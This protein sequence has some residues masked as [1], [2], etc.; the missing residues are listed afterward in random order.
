MWWRSVFDPSWTISLQP[1]N[2]TPWETAVN[3]VD[4]QLVA[5]DPVALVAASRSPADCP[6][7]W[8]PY[9]AAE[10]SVDEF[11]SSWPE[12]RRR[13]VIADALPYHKVK[14]TRGAL[15]RAL[16]PLGYSIRVVEWFEADVYRPPYT[17]RIVATVA[18]D[19]EW[20]A[21]DRAA[22]VRVANSAKNAHTL[23]AGVDVARQHAG[24]M[25]IGAKAITRR[26]LVVG[27]V[28]KPLSMTQTS[29]VFVGVVQRRNRRLV[30][31][32]RQ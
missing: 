31:G 5:R 29:H 8:L 4:G 30:I 17:F 6:V 3:A 21:S 7:D 24:V 13:A 10:R 23:L 28:P 19:I 15:M 25:Y 11:S 22:L 26:R 2:A 14:G 12:D 32:A 1:G 20:R 9:L 18:A 27:Q 16:A